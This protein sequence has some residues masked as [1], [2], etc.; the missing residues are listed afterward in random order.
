[1][2]LAALPACAPRALPAAR[3]APVAPAPPVEEA[4]PAPPI[5]TF[6]AEK[7]MAPPRAPG[8]LLGTAAYDLP[9]EANR[10]V[11][12]ELDFLVYQRHEVV[13]AWLQRADRYR[14]F[15]RDVFASYGLPRD[16]YHL[17]MVESG[18]QPTVRSHA[19]AVGMWQFMYGTGRGMGL[20][21]DD[22]VDE[23]MDPVRSTHAAARHLRQL[24][25]D[26][27]GDWP[28]AAAAYN[29]GAG[30][31]SR[32]I[33]R[34]GARTFWELAERGD[35]AQET[36]RYVPRLYAVTIIAKDP[37]RFGYV[38][39][40]GEARRFAYDSVRVD[41]MT[42]L[43]ELARIGGVAP[44]ELAALN[45]HL[46]RATAPARYWV[47]V[48]AGQGTAMQQAFTA[49][50]FRR[51]GGYELYAVRAGED[52]ASIAASSGLTA[53]EIRS[54]NL[55]TNVERLGRGDRI[56]LWA[57]AVRAIESRSGG[58]MARGDRE[59]SSTPGARAPRVLGIPV[60]PTPAAVAN[61]VVKD[62]DTIWSIARI[63]ESSVDAIR[64]ANGMSA[65]SVLL[66]GQTLR[67]P[68]VAG[69]GG[70]R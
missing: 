69:G 56:R 68:R 61:H 45:P 53:D 2:L 27:G 62:G 40:P 26:F 55:S 28:L 64:G 47:W 48:P 33:S 9:V 52:L 54:L 22:L 49:S 25:R 10:W 17:A 23:R 31:I 14:E 36:R 12:M 58:R 6:A 42:P 35:L 66:T 51:R 38:P 37:R 65:D 11:Q 50:D 24:H 34:Y 21:I 46:R 44:E 57:D 7:R 20:R 67:V 16:L 13:G 30:R 39:L 19:G 70:M 8:G 15:V 1:M 29:A 63:Y 3:P 43:G 4:A 18:F 5:A 32:G 41:V 59:P 60:S